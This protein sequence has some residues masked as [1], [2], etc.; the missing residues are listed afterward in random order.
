MIYNNHRIALIQRSTAHFSAYVISLN[1]N[2]AQRLEIT[3]AN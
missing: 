2:S 3:A 1:E